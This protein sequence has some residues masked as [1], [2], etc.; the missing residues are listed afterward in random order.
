MLLDRGADINAQNNDGCTALQE[1]SLKG[2]EDVVEM[3]LDQEAD[4]NAE[5]NHGLTALQQAS[6]S[7]HVEIVEMLL[8]RG[9][10]KKDSI[11]ALK[12]PIRSHNHTNT[13]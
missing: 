12:S 2:Q 3:L 8:D 7:G 5:D 13:T 1:A 9:A 10:D 11:Q 6:S 4:I